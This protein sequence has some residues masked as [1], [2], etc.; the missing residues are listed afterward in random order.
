MCQRGRD[1]PI[2]KYAHDLGRSDSVTLWSADHIGAAL[3]MAVE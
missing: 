2:K 1:K 3:M